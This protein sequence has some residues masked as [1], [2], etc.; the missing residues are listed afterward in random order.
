[1]IH[2]Y[3][4]NRLSFIIDTYLSLTQ[5]ADLPRGIMICL[6]PFSSALYLQVDLILNEMPFSTYWPKS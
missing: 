5:L 1:M 2:K 4:Y 6:T 3:I